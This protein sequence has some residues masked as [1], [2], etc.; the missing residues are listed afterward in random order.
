MQK[1]KVE[2]LYY[3]S[4]LV[5]F[6][7]L[8]ILSIMGCSHSRGLDLEDYASYIND[9][10]NGYLQSA[11]IDDIRLML[12]YLPPPLLAA[13]EVQNNGVN[14][15][16]QIANVQKTYEGSLTFQLII[17]A[18]DPARN[19]FSIINNGVTTKEE[20]SANLNSLN[21]EL[22]NNIFLQVGEQVINPVLF[23]LESTP[24]L[25]ERLSFLIV[26]PGSKEVLEAFEKAENANLTLQDFFFLSRNQQFV[27]KSKNI[28]DYPQIIL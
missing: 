5:I 14:S 28:V 16:E 12:K 15:K 9:P 7:V 21:Y 27:F 24:D 25:K 17:V 10:S 8:S 11:D 19:L 2:S 20:F 13:R 4:V 26:F 23:N 3:K 18:Q 6:G 22:Q 1:L